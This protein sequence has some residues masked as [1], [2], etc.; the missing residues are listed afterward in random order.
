VWSHVVNTKAWF[1][2]LKGY[3]LRLDSSFSTDWI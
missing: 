2:T 1:L 3:A